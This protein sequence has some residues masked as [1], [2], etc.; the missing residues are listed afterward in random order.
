MICPHCLSQ[1]TGVP[2][3]E[4][5]RRVT[6]LLTHNNELL[7]KYRAEKALRKESELR[8]DGFLLATLAMASMSG[9]VAKELEKVTAE[10]GVLKGAI[11][12]LN[13]SDPAMKEIDT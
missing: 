7:E 10:V 13:A 5:D 3:A 1:H 8:A 4:H 12:A 9:I 11:E 2:A 6:D